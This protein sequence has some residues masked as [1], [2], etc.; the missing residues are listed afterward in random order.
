MRIGIDFGTTTST[1]CRLTPDGRIDMQ[2]PIPSV[3]S[4]KN[5]KWFFGDEAEQLLA[6]EDRAA[7]PVRDLK[8]SL[9]KESVRIGPNH[10]GTEEAV[11][12]FLRYL[13]SVIAKKETIEEAVI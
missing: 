7:Y 13:S 2:G 6:S 9:G 4:W 11:A 8:L 5:G 3:G 12:H 1:I 10:L